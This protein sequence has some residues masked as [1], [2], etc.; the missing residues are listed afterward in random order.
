MFDLE[1]VLPELLYETVAEVPER[2]D[3]H[4]E[5]LE[6][7]DEE[8]GRKALEEGFA[9]GIRSVAIALLHGYRNPAHENRLAQIAADIG[10]TQISVSS[11]TSPLMKLVSRGDTTVTDAYLSPIL[12]RYVEQIR[13]ALD[14]DPVSYTHLTLPTIYPV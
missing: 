3:A 5:V 14:A 9:K 1:I 2:L 4:G 11:T 12:R 8:A 10:Y 13:E 6:P 7:L